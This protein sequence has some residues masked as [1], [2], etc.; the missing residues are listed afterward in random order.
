[1]TGYEIWSSTY[2]A[3]GNA[4]FDMDT[5]VLSAFLD[6]LPVG[7]ALDAACGTGRLTR[8]L[9]GRGHRVI[10]VDSSPAML[11]QAS[12]ADFRQGDLHALPLADSSVDLVTCGLALTHVSDLRPAFA[13]FAR[14]LRPGGHVLI[15]DVHPEG[16]LR[17]SIPTLRADGAPA[18]LASHRHLVGDYLRAA[19]AAGLEVR[20]CEEPVLPLLRWRLIPARTGPLGPVAVGPD[21]DDPGRRPRRE[22]GHPSNAHLGLRPRRLASCERALVVSAL[23]RPEETTSA[24]DFRDHHGDRGHDGGGRH[25]ERG[26]GELLPVEERRLEAVHGRGGR[27]Y[28]RRRQG[29]PVD[30]QRHQSRPALDGAAARGRQRLLPDAEQE[31]PEQVSGRARPVGHAGGPA[32]HLAVQRRQSRP[33][34]E[35]LVHRRAGLRH[36]QQVLRS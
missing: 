15:S 27:A 34:V 2:D 6:A 29:H 36:L 19:L 20:A 32:D 16:V 24:Q 4:A 23:R 35:R 18:R 26:S 9:V 11:A 12:G 7:D 13:E 10:G 21:P 28:G 22:Q 31:G 30:L 25:A 14:A 5:P 3:P 8:L 17:S 1:M 33:A